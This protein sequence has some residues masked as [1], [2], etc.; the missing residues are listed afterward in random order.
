MIIT[1]IITIGLTINYGDIINITGGVHIVG[2][3]F[4]NT[5]LFTTSQLPAE[6]GSWIWCIA[7][8]PTTHAVRLT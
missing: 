5:G 7:T 2:L 3:L 8:C 4:R 6:A 1:M